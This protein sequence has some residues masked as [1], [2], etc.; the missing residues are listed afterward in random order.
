MIIGLGH[1]RG[2]GKST[3]AREMAKLDPRVVL[4]SFAA[5]LKAVC[6]EMFGWAGLQ[7][8]EFYESHPEM[9]DILLP[10]LDIDK[11]P[12][13]IWIEVGMAGRK[14]H[15]DCWVRAAFRGTNSALMIYVFTDLRFPNEACA[16]H[17]RGGEVHNI[18]RVIEKFNDPADSALAKYNGWDFVHFNNTP[19]D[20]KRI[21]KDILSRL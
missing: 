12:R 7:N 20:P 16:I 14:V 1:R 11:T 18:A 15:P 8:A 21:A 10:D 13:E 19:E 3:I 2:V 9:K 6:C 5:P 4:C 17:D